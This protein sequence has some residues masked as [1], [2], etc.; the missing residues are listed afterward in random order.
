MISFIVNPHHASSRLCPRIA[1][2]VTP[3]SAEAQS[4]LVWYLEA[5]IEAIS[6]G[7]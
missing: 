7:S 4:E 3:N 2:G 5:D 6:A 1:R